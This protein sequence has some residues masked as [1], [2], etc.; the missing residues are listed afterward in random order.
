MR[1]RDSSLGQHD[2]D[3]RMSS[4]SSSAIHARTCLFSPPASTGATTLTRSHR[5]SQRP[6]RKARAF[7]R[8]VGAQPPLRPSVANLISST[9]VTPGAIA[10][11]SPSA[12]VGRVRLGIVRKSD[13]REAAEVLRRLLDAVNRGELTADTPAERRNL[14]RLEGMLAALQTAGGARQRTPKD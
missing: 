5:P 1:L 8:G 4:P 6:K 3:S 12:R 13:E 11:E 14:R 10:R 9:G 2:G 7:G